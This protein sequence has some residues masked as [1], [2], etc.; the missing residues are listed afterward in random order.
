MRT[1]NLF[2]QSR[3]IVAARKVATAK[4]LA[5]REL[6]R[7]LNRHEFSWRYIANLGPVLKYQRIRPA[8]NRVHLRL[9]NDLRRDGIVI[10]SVKELMEDARLFEELEAAVA[11]REAVLANELA[12]VRETPNISVKNKSYVVTLLGPQPTLDPSTIFAR[13]ALQPEVVHLV[14]SYLGML[15]RLR[16]YN[17]WHNLVTGQQPRE[18][19]LWHRDPEDR[20]V[21]KMFVYMTDVDKETGPLTYARGTHPLGTVKTEAATRV[22]KEGNTL[23]HRSDD[24]QMRR[25]LSRE[26]WITAVGGKGTVVF[27]D[28]RGYHKGGWVRRRERI[29]YTCMFCSQASIYPEGFKRDLPVPA[30]S[31]SAIAFAIGA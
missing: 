8:L 24:S 30:Y 12:C 7:R 13:F 11:E 27:V 22:F 14:N 20:Y 3:V 2:K 15:A 5:I 4:K 16:Y 17:V 25:V 18:S 19:Q 29:V 6:Y 1:A 31:D 26:K 9:V 23:V 10:T 28:T 21:V